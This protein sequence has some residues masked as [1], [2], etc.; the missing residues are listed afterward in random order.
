MK[1]YFSQYMFYFDS[2]K[3]KIKAFYAPDGFWTL[4]DQKSFKKV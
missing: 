1:A 2:E 3:F 4:Y